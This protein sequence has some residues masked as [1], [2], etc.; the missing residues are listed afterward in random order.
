MSIRM[1][2]AAAAAVVT[3]LAVPLLMQTTPAAAQGA[4][5][6]AYCAI[7][8]KNGTEDCSFVSLA[9]CEATVSG[10]DGICQANPRAGR[11]SAQRLSAQRSRASALNAHAAVVAP[12]DTVEHG[13]FDVYRGDKYLGADPD[14]NVRQKLMQDI[15]VR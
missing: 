11:P 14:V 6:G 12:T 9:Q 1:T 10:D 4:T 7:S 13:R 8:E 3:T 5:R 2:L 15:W